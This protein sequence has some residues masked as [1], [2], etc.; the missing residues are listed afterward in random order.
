[1]VARQ[2]VG[3]QWSGYGLPHC[4]ASKR[5]LHIQDFP[6]ETSTHHK[7]CALFDGSWYSIPF[8]IDLDCLLSI[9][10]FLCLL[11]KFF[12][13]YLL[14]Y[15]SASGFFFVIVLPLNWCRR[16]VER[17]PLI[18][19]LQFPLLLQNRDGTEDN[20]AETES[21]MPNLKHSTLSNG[22]ILG[23]RRSAGAGCPGSSRLDMRQHNSNVLLDCRLAPARRYMLCC[24]NKL[25]FS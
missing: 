23:S 1:V 22:S 5:T 18:S 16:V 12:V 10:D 8:Y 17:F 9:S 13:R 25:H 19:R 24:R 11:S 7:G 21:R 15:S 6:H 3:R 2:V 20:I 14:P 4:E